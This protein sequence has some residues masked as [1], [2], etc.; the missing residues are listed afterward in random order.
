M[1]IKL[2]RWEEIEYKKKQGGELSA[3]EKF[4]YENEPAGSAEETQFRNGLGEVLLEAY[5]EC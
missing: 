4:I 2:P 3:L 1:T 5:S